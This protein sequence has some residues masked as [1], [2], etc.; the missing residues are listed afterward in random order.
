MTR[1]RIAEKLGTTPLAVAGAAN[2]VRA[3]KG[4]LAEWRDVLLQ[5]WLAPLAR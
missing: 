2:R 1:V 4:Q 5:R 3:D